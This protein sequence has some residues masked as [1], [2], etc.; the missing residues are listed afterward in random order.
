MNIK[1]VTSRIKPKVIIQIAIALVPIAF[2]IYFIKHEGYELNQSVSLI[3]NSSPLWLLAGLFIAFAFILCQSKMYVSSFR[4]VDSQISFSSALILALKRGFISVFL[5]AGG[6]SSLA[7][8]TGI[9]ENQG[10]SKTRIHLASLLYG[11]TGFVSLFLVAIPVVFIMLL[12]GNLAT[13][14]LIAFIILFILVSALIL[15][16]RSLLA[17]GL[18]FGIIQ[19]L[20]PKFGVF[21]EE[22]RE[23]QYSVRAIFVTVFW[24]LLIEVCGIAFLYIAMKALGLNATLQI[25]FTGY[26]VATL[27]Y[28]ISPFMRGLGAVEISLTL[29]LLNFGLKQ[30]DALSVTLLYRFFE[31][32]LILIFGALS[33]LYRKDNLILR[34]FPSFLI[35]L[36][37]IVNIFS[38][39]TPAVSVRLKFLKHFLAE[40]TIYFS[41]FTVIIAGVVLIVLSA[42][43]IRGFKNAWTLAFI[44]SILST[45]GHLTKAIDYEEAMLGLL[46]ATTLFYTRK[47]YQ[48]KS[49][50][51]LFHNMKFYLAFGFV[52]IWVYGVVGFTVVDHHHFLRAFSFRETFNYILNTAFFFNDSVVNIQTSFA[53]YFIHSLNFLGALFY[54][55]SIYVLLRPAISR[56][57]TDEEDFTEARAIVN[58]YG[59]SSLDYFKTYN[60]KHIYYDDTK[61]TFI[62]FKTAGDYAVALETPVCQ[63]ESMI[64]DIVCDF[65]QYCSERGLITLY[66]RVDEKHLPHF[67]KSNKKSLLIGQEGLIDIQNFSLQGKDMKSTRNK[68][69]KVESE[70]FVCK[71]VEPPIKEGLIQKLKAVSFE[72]LTNDHK[73]ESAFSQGVFDAREMKN[74]VI[75]LIENSE[76]KVVAFTNIIPDY[77][78]GEVTYDL[79]RKTNDAPGGVLD[80]LIV[81][82]ISYYKARGEKFL[83][84]GLAPFS[85]IEKGKNLPEKTIH[86]VYTNLKPMGHYERLRFFKEKY[87]SVWLN[88]YLVYNTN[89]DLIRA[90]LAIAKVS[91]YKT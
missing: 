50:K 39:L 47:T 42:Y 19:R 34:I 30:V 35:F 80:V 11:I 55:T 18:V 54:L 33:F 79:I 7:F 77:A 69:N 1:S 26:V 89:Y 67:E 22:L 27:F 91:K 81:E 61:S 20:T 87:A 64:G 76:E 73:M 75:F 48:L 63:D 5:P 78:A 62:A 74:H 90:P 72:W 88:K 84:L 53:R 60:D 56:F 44:I 36:L 31:F 25:A 59:N 12:S 2:S 65:D 28:A 49:D 24:S 6:V 9:I 85:G 23:Q 38:V 29:I 17:E 57:Y 68:I 8:Y 66:Y 70:G 58:K 14:V 10:V 82:M 13:N 21:I 86:F 51:R 46:V 41:N 4:A 40:D 32:W 45:I 43:L 37:G 16:G 71:I 15:L 52:F 3:R 83:N